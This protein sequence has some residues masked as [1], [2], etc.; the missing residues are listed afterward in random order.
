MKLSE[1]LQPFFSIYLIYKKT[2]G[3]GCVFRIQTICEVDTMLVLSKNRFLLAFLEL[4]LG[5]RFL[6]I[7][8]LGEG[9][10]GVGVGSD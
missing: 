5:G 7:F 6:A 4:S 8:S 1:E 3:L 10:R 9:T 2:C